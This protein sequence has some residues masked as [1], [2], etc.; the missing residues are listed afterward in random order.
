IHTWAHGGL[1]RWSNGIR[2]TSTSWCQ[3]ISPSERIIWASFSLVPSMETS[4]IVSNPTR[5]QHGW[6][7]LGKGKTKWTRSVDEDGRSSR[8]DNSR[9]DSIFTKGMS[10]GSQRKK[11]DEQ[12]SQT[13]IDFALCQAYKVLVIASVLRVLSRE[14][15]RPYLKIPSM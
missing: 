8:R 11:R 12:T 15:G 4:I 5:R 13:M 7:F 1:S 14:R 6:N 10:Q 3:A 2:M 9:E